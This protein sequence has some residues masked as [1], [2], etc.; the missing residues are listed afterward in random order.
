MK[1]KCNHKFLNFPV[2]QYASKKKLLF[3]HNEALV[4]D[5][6]VALDYINPAY[7]MPVNI[8][9]FFGMEIEIKTEPEM[10]IDIHESDEKLVYPADM[11]Y[12]PAFHFSA[13]SGWIND[14]NG[15]FRYNGMYHLFF[16]YNPAG[17]VWDNMHWGHAASSDL[18]HWKEL[19]CALYPDSSG[20]MFSGSAI[21]DAK[22]VTGLKSGSHD[23]ILLFYTAAG[24]TSRLSQNTQFTQCLAYSTD[25]GKTF[26]KYSQNPILP[27]IFK[28]NRDPKVIYDKAIDRYIMALYLHEHTY[29]LFTSDNLLQWTKLQEIILQEDTECPD[30]YP[31]PIDGNSNNIQ[32]VFCGAADRYVTGI[33]GGAG[34]APTSQEKQL[35]FGDS[36]YASQSWSN[37]SGYRRVRIAWNTFSI[38]GMPFNNCMTFPCEMELKQINDE[39]YLCSNPVS[40]IKNL[41]TSEFAD[42]NITV[43]T[44]KKYAAVLNGK[45][46]DIRMRIESATEFCFSFFGLNIQCS[47]Q[48]NQLKCNNSTAPLWHRDGMTEL[49][50]LIDKTGVEIFIDKGQ[51]YLSMGHLMDYNLNQFEI[52]GGNLVIHQI[53]IARIANTI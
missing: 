48:K 25:G 14:P 17:V 9:R 35:H 19:D 38:P 49:R 50:L 12:R 34:F 2:N 1:F 6:D 16:Q 45:C 40:E 13:N 39:I 26:A 43:K 46:F 21:V 36:S 51:A 37:S 52:L 22:N 31:L 47:I 24:G 7:Y 15:L 42:Q 30:F 33:F 8:E 29:A 4:Y 5:L 32:W 11:A 20:T 23:V 41:Y 18:L 27:H 44:E 53:K 28:S 10:L 3:Y